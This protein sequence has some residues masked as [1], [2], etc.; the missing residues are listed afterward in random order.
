LDHCYDL[1]QKARD[2][3]LHLVVCHV[4]RYSNH[5]KKIKEILRSGELGEVVRINHTENVA[6][7]HFAH[8][9]VRGNWHREDE[10]SPSLLAKCCHDIDLLQWFMERPC[11]SVSSRGDIAYFNSSNAPKGAALR[12]L[13]G[14][15]AK[16]TCPYDAERL[17]IKDPFYRATFI[18]YMGRTL[19]HKMRSTKAEKYKAIREG[20]YGKCVYFCNNDVM[21]HQ[22][23]L[24]DFGEGRR[25]LHNMYGLTDK[26]FRK[27]HIVCEKGE[28]I[29][30]DN[31]GKITVNI[32]GG[33]RKK[34]RTRWITAGGH[35][36]GDIRLIATF[37][38]FLNGETVKT[39]DMTFIDATIPSHEIIAVAEESRK[40]GGLPL[41]L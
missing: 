30:Q 25:V 16:D 14:C 39:E 29:S 15:K 27:T 7:F 34:V 32:F 22:E 19:T 5:Y 20:D 41:P 4:L 10:T 36:E 6:Y 3:G 13:D 12:C 21:D 2:K 24:M 11:Q 23:V 33:K 35:I 1:Q 31:K 26:M 18:K 37:L 17:Y 38:K 9:Y 28:I 40:Q 8:S